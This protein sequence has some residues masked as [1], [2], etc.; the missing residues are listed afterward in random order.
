MNLGEFNLDCTACTD[1]MKIERGCERDS[2]IPGKWQIGEYVFQ[3]CPKKEICADVGIYI[4]A[5][6]FYKNGILP[7][8]GGWLNQTAKF[9]EAINLIDSEMNDITRSQLDDIKKPEVKYGKRPIN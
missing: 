2:P 7:N 6:N 9:I 1:A 4:Q 3:R 8:A 5:Y